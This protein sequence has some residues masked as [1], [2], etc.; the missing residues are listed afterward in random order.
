[1]LLQLFKQD[2][3][4]DLGTANTLIYVKGKG[5]ILNEP[6]VVAVDHQSKEVLATGKA[7]KDM[8]GRAPDSIDVVRPLEDGVI[9]DFGMTQ[10][11]L[12]EFIRRVIKNNMF[13]RIRIVVGVPSGVTEVEKRAVEEVARQMGAKDVYILDEPM[14]AA[15]GAGLLVDKAEGCMVADIGGGTSDIAIISLGGIVTSTSLRFAGDKMND[16]IITYMRKNYNIMVGLKSAEDAKIKIGCAWVDQDDPEFIRTYNIK[17]RDL[18]SG[19]PRTV[20]INSLD[21]M[22][23]LEEPINLIIDGIK[24]TLEKAPPELS[25]DIIVTGL[26]LAG[27][28]ALLRGLDRLIEEQTGMKIIVSED[29]IEAV[30]IGTGKSL[31]HIDRIQRY[32]HRNQKY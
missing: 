15:I 24:S 17:G 10:V 3:G 26:T 1:M 8:I 11:M 20:E 30:A 2:I 21:I 27:G 9:S 12:R 5:I 29:A 23:A 16:A 25:A 31:E 28:G 7:A 22:K 18:I 4:I 14:A 19:L 13:T 6:S 32:T